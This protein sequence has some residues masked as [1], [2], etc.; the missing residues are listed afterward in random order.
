M[1]K[2]VFQPM[3]F[4]DL[5]ENIAMYGDAAKLAQDK[6]DKWLSEQP[7]VFGIKIQH[8]YY[9]AQTVHKEGFDTHQARLVDIQPIE[10]EK[11]E[12]EPD[13]ILGVPRDAKFIMGK[14]LTIEGEPSCK[15]CGIKLRAV[16]GPA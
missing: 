11:C 2:L 15:H 16:W 4:F 8:E 12:H 1:S 9:A 5:D 13:L 10:K 6:F 7:V 14:K 3:D